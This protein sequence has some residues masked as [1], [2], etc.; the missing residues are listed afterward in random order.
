MET[1]RCF[2]CDEVKSISHFYKHKQMK[3][4]HL[5]KCI[6]CA[7]IDI[8]IRTKV[9]KEDSNWVEKER[10]RGRDKYHRLGYK[11]KPPHESKKDF[12]NS[13]K[14][15]YPE[16][17][18]AHIKAQR[19]SRQKGNHLHH[20]SYNEEHWTDVIELTPEDHYLLHRFIEYDKDS[21]M[22][23]FKIENKILVTKES[24]IE[25]LIKIKNDI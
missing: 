14:E 18:H 17:Y 3:D 19:I 10:K 16:K 5:N 24:H 13:Y 2:K 12:Q 21:K 25:L 1:K 8:K 20:W 7:K 9:L 6:D 23:K 11:N 15:K 22:Y 4:G